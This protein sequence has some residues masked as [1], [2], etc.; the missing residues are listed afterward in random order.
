MGLLEPV[1]YAGPLVQ[2][3]ISEPAVGVFHS[4]IRGRATA[5]A[6]SAMIQFAEHM[7]AAQRRLLVFHD[8]EAVSGYDADARKLLTEWSQRITPYWDGSHILF[9]SPLIAMAVSVASLTLRGKIKTYSSRANF[10][11]SLARACAR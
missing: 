3:R 6:A 4:V 11:R 5:G 7:L 1:D 8:W 9:S 2:V 10:E